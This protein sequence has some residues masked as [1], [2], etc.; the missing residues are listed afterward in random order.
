[1]CSRIEHVASR[2]SKNH[3]SA[4]NGQSDIS[5]FCGHSQVSEVALA[6]LNSLER[7]GFASKI[8]VD[9]GSQQIAQFQL[10]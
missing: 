10:P 7:A 5:G 1:M 9:P 4:L 3:F 2:L 6:S 8:N